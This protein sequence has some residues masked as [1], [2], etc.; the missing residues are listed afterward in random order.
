MLPTPR[1]AQAHADGGDAGA[2][3]LSCYGIH[4][5]ELLFEFKGNRL[6]FNIYQWPG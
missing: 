4:V 3:V 5:F 2:D 6:L 1:A